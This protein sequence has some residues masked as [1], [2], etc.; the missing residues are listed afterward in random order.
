MILQVG[1][2]VF[3]KNQEGKYLLIKRSPVKYPD[4]KDPWD[5]VGGRID[6]GSP[7]LENLKREVKEETG[8]EITSEPRLLAAQDIIPNSE[9]HVVRLTYVADTKGE[10]VL[11]TSEN[12]EYKWVTIE[13]GKNKT[14]WISTRE[15]LS[16]EI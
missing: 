10:P 1:V 12:T 8:L 7:L 3:L 13:G 5:I 16:S 15:R 9:K 14:G 6:S 11:D 4:V 2:K